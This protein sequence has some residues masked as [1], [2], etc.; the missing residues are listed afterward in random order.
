M[1]VQFKRRKKIILPL[2]MGSLLVIIAILV[3]LYIAQQFAKYQYGITISEYPLPEITTPTK[4]NIVITYYGKKPKDVDIKV[5]RPNDERTYS[6]SA[7]YEYDD[8][9]K[10]IY[11]TYDVNTI[12]HQ[13][14]LQIKPADNELVTVEM[15]QFKS[16]M[17]VNAGM[18]VTEDDKGL[19]VITIENF[20]DKLELKVNMMAENQGKSYSKHVG[21]LTIAPGE[22]TVIRLSE[23]PEKYPNATRLLI[24]VSDGTDR[25][26]MHQTFSWY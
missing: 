8:E 5:I 26:S 10:K 11:I 21:S 18:T 12:D 17:Y 24:N 25:Q 9:N 2:I 1:A 7:D 19:A 23:Y 3:G 15:E 20:D 4:T 14:F 13:Y 6:A 16:D 22:S